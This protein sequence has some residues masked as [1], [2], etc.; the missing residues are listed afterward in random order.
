LAAAAGRRVVRPAAAGG[1]IPAMPA[2][3]GWTRDEQLV[4]LRLYKRAEWAA[5]REPRTPFGRLHARNPEI[6]SLAG[7][8]GRTPSALAMNGDG[9]NVLRTFSAPRMSS[10]SFKG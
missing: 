3:T 8:L 2:G 9:S 4:A 10:A 1:I 5:A 7:H 6:I